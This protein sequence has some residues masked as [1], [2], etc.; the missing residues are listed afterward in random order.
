MTSSNVCQ[1]AELR[2]DLVPPAAQSIFHAE[3]QTLHAVVAAHQG[4]SQRSITLCQQAMAA[5][6]ENH[7]FHSIALLVLGMAYSQMGDIHKA[8]QKLDALKRLGEVKKNTSNITMSEIASSSGALL[9]GAVTRVAGSQ[10]PG[11]DEIRQLHPPPST[12][13]ACSMR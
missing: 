13:A 2:S 8:A 1:D 6:P 3:I 12:R 5:L 10:P 4:L 7:A 9:T 11:R